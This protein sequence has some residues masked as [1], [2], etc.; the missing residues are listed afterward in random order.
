METEDL[1]NKD[2]SLSEA[3]DVEG[4]LPQTPDILGEAD[5]MRMTPWQKPPPPG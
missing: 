5:D 1:Q 2:Y 4:L 3:V